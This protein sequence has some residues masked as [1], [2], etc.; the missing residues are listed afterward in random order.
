MVNIFTEIINKSTYIDK[1]EYRKLFKEHWADMKKSFYKYENLQN[2][3]D[4]SKFLEMYINKDFKGMREIITSLYTSEKE[5]A[6]VRE[7]KNIN[8]IRVHGIKYPLSEYIKLEALIYKIPHKFGQKIYFFDKDREFSNKYIMDFV[9]FDEK[10]IFILDF[11]DEKLQGVWQCT[12]D[13]PQIEKL[14]ELFRHSESK[15]NDFRELGVADEEVN[16][17][18]EHILNI[19][20]DVY[21]EK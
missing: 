21:N 13:I 17:A 20:K 4:D 18:I 10:I 3:K 8:L 19:G 5:L 12:E 15:L 1:V 9:I 16:N 6:K 11:C 14:C 7:N 2:Y